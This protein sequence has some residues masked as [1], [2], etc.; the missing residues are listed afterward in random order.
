ML[1]S[2]TFEAFGETDLCLVEEDGGHVCGIDGSQ[3]RNRLKRCHGSCGGD[4]HLLTLWSFVSLALGTRPLHDHLEGKCSP[5][6]ETSLILGRDEVGDSEPAILTS[7][8]CWFCLRTIRGVLLV[9]FGTLISSGSGS[10][11]HTLGSL[12]D[13]SL[14][15]WTYGVLNL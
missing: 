5:D 14:V 11:L 12:K 6:S 13:S 10:F 3:G 2:W 9:S 15:P 8:C 7:S 4:K 1:S